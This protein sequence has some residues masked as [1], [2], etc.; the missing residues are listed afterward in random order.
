MRF[1]SELSPHSGWL[2]N[3]DCRLKCIL[4][5]KYCQALKASFEHFDLTTT[6]MYPAS[7]WA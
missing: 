1:E 7:L 6:Q 4:L 5:K 3:P 2:L